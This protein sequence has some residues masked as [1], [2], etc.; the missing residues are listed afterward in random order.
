ML[1][2]SMAQSSSSMFTIGCIVYRQE[3]VFFLI[4]NAL[5]AGKLGMGVHSVG[6]VCCL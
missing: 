4:E 3:R 6:K 2:V 1:P 5:L